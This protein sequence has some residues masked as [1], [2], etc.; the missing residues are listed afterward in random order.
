MNRRYL[1]ASL[2]AAPLGAC[3]DLNKPMTEADRQWWDR[4]ERRAEVRRLV[5][6]IDSERAAARRWR[7]R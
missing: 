2:L 3:A 4:Y 6:E 7:R 5:R 1:L